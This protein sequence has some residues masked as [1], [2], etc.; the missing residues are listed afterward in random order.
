MK[1]EAAEHSSKFAE[2]HYVQIYL[3]TPIATNL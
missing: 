2:W 3:R 1:L